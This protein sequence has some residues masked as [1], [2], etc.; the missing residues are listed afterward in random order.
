M[1][2]TP[3]YKDNSIICPRCDRHE[4]IELANRKVQCQKKGKERSKEWYFCIN[5]MPEDPDGLYYPFSYLLELHKEN[6][7]EQFDED[8][9]IAEGG[10]HGK[11]KTMFFSHQSWET[12]GEDLENEV[13]PWY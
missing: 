8:D 10:I 5:C 6:G 9:F 13:S 1:K 7:I 12:S 3:Q 4:F 2:I 11:V